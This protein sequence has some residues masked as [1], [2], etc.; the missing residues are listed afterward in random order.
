M[1]KA[2]ALFSLLALLIAN[3]FFSN[4][5]SQDNQSSAI[6]SKL[7]KT[8]K[9]YNSI[10]ASFAISIKNKQNASSVRQSG[11]LYQKGKKFRVNMSG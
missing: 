8:Y 9:T 2:F 1:K 10:K 6:L 4:S 7:S 11:T 5:E 3:P